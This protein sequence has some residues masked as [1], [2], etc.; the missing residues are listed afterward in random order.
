MKLFISSFVLA[1]NISPT[2]TGLL[3]SI[4]MVSYR[5]I[6]CKTYGQDNMYTKLNF[7]CVEQPTQLV[8]E[9]PTHMFLAVSYFLMS[10]FYPNPYA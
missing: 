6:R 7:I 5:C 8:S 9:K 10:T 1:G 4:L 3:N 2:E